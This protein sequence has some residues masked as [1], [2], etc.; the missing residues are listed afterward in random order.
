MAQKENYGGTQ[1]FDLD[2]IIAYLENTTEESWCT[3]VVKTNDG[4]NCLLGH[5]FDFGGNRV[6]DIFEECVATTYMFYSVNDG[7]H[8]KYKQESPKQRILAYIKDIK[9]GVQPS[10][11]KLMEEEWNNYKK[12]NP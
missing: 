4:K 5:L 2:N 3:D 1:E 11:Q 8:P 7:T 6:M 12:I 10:T 9:S